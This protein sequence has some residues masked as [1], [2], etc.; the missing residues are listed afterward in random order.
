MQLIKNNPF[1]LLGL[2]A[3][4]SERELQ[5]QLSI[6][7]RFVEVKQDKSFDYDFT[8]LGPLNR[9][10]ASVKE[11]ANKIEQSTNRVFY[12]LHWFINYNHID[13]TAVGYLKQNNIEKAIQIWEKLVN[14]SPVN[15]S[16]F[17]AYS[18]LSTIILGYKCLNGTV[19][20]ENLEKGMQLKL[21]LLSSKAFN[22]FS[23]AVGGIL[24][25]EDADYYIDKFFSEILNILIRYS[26]QN[27]IS[28]KQIIDVFSKLPGNAKRIALEKFT[29]EPIRKI[30][31]R[32][33]NT[34][35]ERN[36]NP[37]NGYKLGEKL[38]LDCRDELHQLKDIFGVSNL[39]YQSVA[40]KVASEILQC[41]IEYFNAFQNDFNYDPGNDCYR[42]NK[43]ADSIAVNGT[44]K[45]R[46]KEGLEYLTKW[47]QERPTREVYNK[48]NTEVEFIVR[49]I[50]SIKNPGMSDG[51]KTLQDCGPKLV[52]IKN[53]LG[54]SSPVYLQ[55]CDIV[56]GNVM[57]TAVTNFNREVEISTLLY[58]PSPNL[59]NITYQAYTLLRSLESYDMSS[60]LRN[61]LSLNLVTIKIANEKL[62]PSGCFIATLVYGDYDHPQVKILRTF[63]DKTL[64]STNAGRRIVDFYYL[65][66][67]GIVKKLQN[68][69][70]IQKIIRSFLNLIIRITK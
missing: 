54:I 61:R 26:K 33:D 7:K 49:H 69:K 8:F 12:G 13:E 41:S 27:K 14:S 35:Q 42:L 46:I 62:N 1:R 29:S 23:D 18:N 5:K 70:L 3:N 16:N 45:H 2:P 24:S 50:E 32:V 6:I 25:N 48:I 38:F 43:Y 59:K 34:T 22:K 63:R 66:S 47:E 68:R 4:A 55:W 17:N 10:E 60:E 19:A 20:I 9:N 31:N 65:F 28:S 21:S 30:E 67:P 56:V 15:E 64:L 57:S 52:E 37:Q 11:A 58:S 51:V 53:K 39:Q 36:K 44:V 40:N